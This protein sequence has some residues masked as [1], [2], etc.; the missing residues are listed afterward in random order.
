[1]APRGLAAIVMALAVLG[2]AAVVGADRPARWDTFL[3]VGRVGP[4]VRWEDRAAGVQLTATVNV[5][6]LPIM[7]VQRVERFRG[8]STRVLGGVMIKL[9]AWVSR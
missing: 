5:F 8:D 4:A 9:P 7:P 1:M 3:M 6:V 2:P